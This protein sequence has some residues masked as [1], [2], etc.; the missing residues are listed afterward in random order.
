[1]GEYLVYPLA[2]YQVNLN[3][4]IPL[5]IAASAPPIIQEQNN[6]APVYIAENTRNITFAFSPDYLEYA[7][8][9]DAVTIK[10]YVFPEHAHLGQRAAD[11][12]AEAWSL[13]ENLCG[14]NPRQFMVVIEA[15]LHDGMEYDGAFLLSQDYFAS[16]DDSPQNY[17]ELLIVHET[18][19]QWFYAQI[20]NDQAHEPWLDE[21]FAT[22]SE[23]LYLENTH[24]ELTN[25]WWNYRVNAYEPTGWVDSTI[26]DHGSF[27]P[28]VNAVYLRGVQFIHDLRQRIGDDAFFTALRDYAA[29]DDED[30]FRSEQDFFDSIATYSQEDIADLLG[31]YFQSSHP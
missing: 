21:A 23:L 3:L 28:Y 22:Y 26:Y 11:L 15:D 20:A 31:L 4:S 17:Y 14:D 13:Y 9:S 8:T 6:P 16:A 19:H 24:P 27:R 12:A 30:D 7:H 5:V 18:A 10:A 29:S 2:N 1:V 25:W